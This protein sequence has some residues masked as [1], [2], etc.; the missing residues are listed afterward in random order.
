MI[1]SNVAIH[2][3]MDE[4]R[5]LIK[6]EPKPRFKSE[7]NEDCPYQTTSVD[8]RLSNE[9]SR[10][11]EGKGM[12]ISLTRGRFQ[13]LSA[14]E[15]SNRITITDEQPFNLEP[16][17]FILGQTHERVALPLPKNAGDLCYAARIEGRSSY[18]RAGLLVHFTAPTIH[19]GF[20]LP[21]RGTPITLELCNFG[22]YSIEL[23]PGARI[24]QL[25]FEEV[26]GIPVKNESQF[27]AQVT[28]DGQSI[29]SITF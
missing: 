18:A 22:R 21:D 29:S 2:K 1:L 17:K 25:I 28:P 5:I 16:G 10:L 4:G 3:A 7:G 23:R 9:L 24:C 26:S 13:D 8:L 19:A 20:G 12:V 27:Q 6:P 15:N 14:G 11:T